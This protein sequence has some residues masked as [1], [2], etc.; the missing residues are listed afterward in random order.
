MLNSHGGAH[1]VLHR[2]GLQATHPGFV[3]VWATAYPTR[4]AAEQVLQDRALGADHR[5]VRA[6]DIGGAITHMQAQLAEAD[7]ARRN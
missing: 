5:I 2:A 4:A 6:R 7:A 1:A 3:E